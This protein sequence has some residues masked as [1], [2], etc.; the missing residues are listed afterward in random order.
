MPHQTA[1]Y[2]R[3][4]VGCLTSIV[5]ILV[6]GDECFPSLPSAHQRV[7]LQTIS[8]QFLNPFKHARIIIVVQVVANIKWTFLTLDFVTTLVEFESVGSFLHFQIR[9]AVSKRACRIEGADLSGDEKLA[10]CNFLRE[11]F[12]V[13]SNGFVFRPEGSCSLSA[14]SFALLCVGHGMNEVVP[15]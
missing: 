13:I 12:V 1:V 3:L 10:H 2:D 15:I 8:A 5:L 7:K 11:R 14:R 9:L 6:I 4:I